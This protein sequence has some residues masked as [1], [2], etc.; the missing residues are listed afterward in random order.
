MASDTAVLKGTLPPLVAYAPRCRHYYRRAS[1][2]ELQKEDTLQIASDAAIASTNYEL[3]N[4]ELKRQYLVRIIDLYNAIVQ[5]LNGFAGSFGTGY[6]FYTLDTDLNGTLPVIEEQIR[7]NLELSHAV[8]AHQGESWPCKKCLQKNGCKMADLK[9]MCNPCDKVETILKP[10]KVINRLPDMDLWMVCRQENIEE[11]KRKIISLLR[12]NHFTSSDTDPVRTIKD[13]KEIA[14]DL[15][16]GIMPRKFVPIDTHIIDYDT[17]LSLIERIPETLAHAMETGEIP[18]LPIHPISYR[19]DWQQDDVPYN[20]VHDYLSSFTS[21][22]FE[23]TIREKL[24]NTRKI[25]SK[26]YTIDELYNFLLMSGPDSAKRRNETP[27]LRK[28]F[29]KKVLEWQQ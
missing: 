11:N 4:T 5:D 12:Q 3:A 10:R 20:F 23:P 18:Y 28:T 25:I 1:T 24:E 8:V 22:N 19:K 16:L 7:Y 2:F 15:Q 21:F 26:L 9:V 17:L 14:E 29:E 13:V 27:A 6:P